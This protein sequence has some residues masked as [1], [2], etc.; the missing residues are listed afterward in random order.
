[1]EWASDAGTL[2]GF[3]IGQGLTTETSIRGNLLMRHGLTWALSAVAL[4]WLPG[5]G[6][7]SEPIPLTLP[8]DP[9]GSSVPGCK[10]VGEGAPGTFPAV[11]AEEAEGYFGER[12]LGFGFEPDKG[13][14]TFTTP[15]DT[16]PAF[17]V[18]S[19]IWQGYVGHPSSF[20][21]GRVWGRASSCR[22]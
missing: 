11:A 18:T 17:D 13:I 7:S 5:Q 9:S 14:T 1:M 6:F 19:L 3:R 2:A 21:Q 22:P 15:R 20:R 4:C 8:P 16:S 12:I 10:V